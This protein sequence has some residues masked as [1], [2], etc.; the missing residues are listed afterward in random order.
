MG[1]KIYNEHAS[2]GTQGARRLGDGCRGIGEK[3]QHL[4]DSHNIHGCSGHRQIVDI[5]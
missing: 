1:G 3:V 4:M 5:S 2:A